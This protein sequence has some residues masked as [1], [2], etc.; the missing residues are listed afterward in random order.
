MITCAVIPAMNEAG[1]IGPVIEAARKHADRVIVVDDG[2][3]DETLNVAQRAGARVFRHGVN[4]GKG[5]ALKTGC[6]A[7]TRL[8]A[9]IIVIL[10]ADGQHDPEDIPKLAEPIEAGRADVVFGARTEVT[11]GKMPLLFTFGNWFLSFS[12]KALFGAAL[13]DTQSGFRAFR[14]DCMDRLLWESSDYAVETEMITRGVRAGL[15]FHEVEIRS[16]YEEKYKGTTVFDGLKI[17]ANLLL[18]R[19]T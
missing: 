5:A 1:R 15:R 16:S 7:A 10:D 2:S 14:S 18:W 17:F 3:T 9:E 8:G 11:S 6:L 19:L 4:L 13:R 12:V